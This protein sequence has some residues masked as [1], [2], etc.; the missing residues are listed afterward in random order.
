MIVISGASGFLGGALRARAEARGERVV[1]IGRST[2]DTVA[3]PSAGA[4]FTEEAGRALEG[5]RALI[6]LAGST[7]GV[8]WTRATRRAIR[9]SRV[10]LTEALSRALAATTQRPRVFVAASAV[11]IYGDCGDSWLDETSPPGADY[12]GVVAREWE[13]ATTPARDAG[14]RTVNLRT[15]VVLGRGGGMVDKLRLPTL[16]GGGARLGSGR[17]WM[18]WIALIDFLRVVDRV[19]EDASMSGPVNVVSPSPV[20]NAEFT[21]E[22]ARALRRPALVGIPA[23][24]LRAVFGEMA[25]AVLLASQR[26]RPARLEAAGFIFEHPTLAGALVE[27]LR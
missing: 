22:F 26:V 18:S 15:G 19:I 17:Q 16:L 4:A 24:A 11:G 13:A 3:W 21:R 6:H 27:A 23:F 8:R 14:I 12:L 25:D 10:P 1:T 7:I 5:A 9:E 20:T 2:T